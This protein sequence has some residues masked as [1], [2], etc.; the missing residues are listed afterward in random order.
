MKEINGLKL[1]SHEEIKD[2]FIG[3]MGS[4]KRKNY[5]KSLKRD[6]NRNKKKIN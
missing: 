4:S 6:K 2:Q 5:D 1:Y 3:K